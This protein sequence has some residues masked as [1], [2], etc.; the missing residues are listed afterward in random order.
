MSTRERVLRFFLIYPAA[1]CMTLSS[2]GN[3]RLLFVL[4]TDHVYVNHCCVRAH[5]IA[6]T[7]G[8]VLKAKAFWAI[9]P[10]FYRLIFLS[11][12]LEMHWAYVM[13]KKNLQYKKCVK[14]CTLFHTVW[15]KNKINAA[16]ALIINRTFFCP[17]AVGA[18]VSLCASLLEDSKPCAAD[19]FSQK[20]WQLES[21]W[22]IAKKKTEYNLKMKK[23]N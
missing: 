17:I 2:K 14:K 23:K 19:L 22:K 6:T 10:N 3:H 18:C 8:R 9:L 12:R 21:Q 5:S 16:R 7:W 13:E 1:V 11:W 20:H 4:N 15:K